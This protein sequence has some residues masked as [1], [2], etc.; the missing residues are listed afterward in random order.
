MKLCPKTI[1]DVSQSDILLNENLQE[2][3]LT[4][5]QQ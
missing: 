5:K 2:I 1:H 4:M 3:H